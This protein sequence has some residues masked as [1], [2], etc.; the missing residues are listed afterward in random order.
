MWPIWIIASESFDSNCQLN[1][2]Y[3]DFSISFDQ[4]DLFI[5]LRKESELICLLSYS[6]RQHFEEIEGLKSQPFCLSSGVPQ[7]ANPTLFCLH[8]LW[9]TY[10]KSLP[11]TNYSSLATLTDWCWTNPIPFNIEKCNNL[12][13]TRKPDNIT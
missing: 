1:V 3:T 9:K 11:V 8:S 13:F 2:I 7:G 10:Y 12:T 5:V 6:N 4:I